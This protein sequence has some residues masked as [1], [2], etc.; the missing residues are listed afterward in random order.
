MRNF[1]KEPIRMSIHNMCHGVT[2]S[3]TWIEAIIFIYSLS[4]LVWQE[5]EDR[6]TILMHSRM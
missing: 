3:F 1:S 5:T 6:M 4:D 2:K